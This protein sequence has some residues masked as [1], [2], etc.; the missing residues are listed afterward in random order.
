[1][2][3]ATLLRN[4]AE[5]GSDQVFAELVGRHIDMVYASARRMVGGDAHL[6]GD[7]AQKV[8]ADLARKAGQ[9][10]RDV[11]LGGWLYQHTCF[12]AANAVRNERRRQNREEQAAQMTSDFSESETVWRQLEPML[13][14]GL[15]LLESSD[16]DAI[17]MRFFEKRPFR[18]VGEA[19]GISEDAARKRVER[20]VEKLHTF[21][22]E[23]GVTAPT[24]TVAEAMELHACS[25]TPTG[26]SHKIAASSI[27]KPGQPSSA[28][29]VPVKIAAGLAIIGVGAFMAGHV[30]HRLPPPR[31][32]SVATIRYNFPAVPVEQLFF[33]YAALQKEKVRVS[34]NS[35]HN[36]VVKIF[37]P[38]P[39]TKEEAAKLIETALAD[40]DR[41]QI[42]RASDGTLMAVAKG[43]DPNTVTGPFETIFPDG[44]IESP[45]PQPPGP[46]FRPLLRAQPQ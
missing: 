9:L 43:Q 45:Y 40:Q 35:P 17:L 34:L 32:A 7:V 5:T 39:V 30:L 18:A 27:A 12:T 25:G 36:G 23:R 19:L 26:L 22:M 2:N 28:R 46:V 11:F 38:Q 14:E 20:A 29:R 24:L 31:P 4:F 33:I 10:P 6:A 15:G 44:K 21:F 41:I 37:T 3:D 16:R 1:M 42:T 13:D 8:F